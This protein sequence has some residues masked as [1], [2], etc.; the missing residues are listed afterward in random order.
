M[1]WQLLEGRAQDL[2]PADYA[3][4]V[5]MVFTSP[6]YD[7][8]RNFDG[9]TE[10]AWEFDAV[11]DAVIACLMPG[12]VICWLESDAIVDGSESGTAFRNALALKAKGLR[13][14]QTTIYEKWNINGSSHN[15][16][17]RT[18]EYVFVLSLG[19]PRVANILVDRPSDAPGRVH[20][21]RRSLGRDADGKATYV[22]QYY[23]TP[24]YTK[25]GSVWS[26]NA[27]VGAGQPP[28]EGMVPYEHPS[29]NPYPLTA[30]H[31]RTWSDPGDLILDPMAGSGTTGRAAVNHG[32]RAVM[33]EVNPEYCKIIQKRM[34]QQVL[35]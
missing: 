24:Q 8:L 1:D 28:A 20:R 13:L 26:Y 23:E 3:G 27:R 31:I 32:R 11:T 4:Q 33:C 16:Y 22:K 30:D 21:E 18:H 14:H 35:V 2:L 25:R 19:A 29:T 7:G 5:A 34:A 10:S 15:R 6:P 17:F 9:Y 12:G